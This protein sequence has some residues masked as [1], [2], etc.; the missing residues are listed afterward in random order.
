MNEIICFAF[1]KHIDVPINH[2]FSY[3]NE[4]KHVLEWN[5]YVVENVYEGKESDIKV[6]STF[7]T[8]QK[9]GKKIIELE[10]E[11]GIFN[12][13]FNAEVKTSTKEGISTTRYTLVKE[14]GGTLF[15]V[16]AFLIPKNY[17]YS[18]VTKMFKWTFKLMYDEQYEKFIEYTLKNYKKSIYNENV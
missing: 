13:P 1:L 8:K 18:I 11:Y 3:L 7:I 17:Y 9:V 14:N 16:E 6:G 12:P 4:D 10:A 5:D 2:V 15:R